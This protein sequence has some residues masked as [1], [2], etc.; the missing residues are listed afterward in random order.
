[1]QDLKTDE[2]SGCR[3]YRDESTSRSPDFSA[4]PPKNLE[5]APLSVSDRV[6]LFTSPKKWLRLSVE[7]SAKSDDSAKSG[8]IY[9]Q[10]S[11]VSLAGKYDICCLI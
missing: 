9:I 6:R 8:S 7:T 1:M 2:S 11:C 4:I 5:K 3:D 10:T